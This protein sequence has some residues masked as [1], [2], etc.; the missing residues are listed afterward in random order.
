MAPRAAHALATLAGHV[1]AEARR[2]GAGSSAERW[3]PRA[4][5]HPSSAEATASLAGQ[6]RRDLAC[7]WQH[8]AGKA[9]WRNLPSPVA[10]HFGLAGSVAGEA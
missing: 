4:A 1:Q 10:S 5:E 2:R 6:E 9:S 7:L 3:P 8:K